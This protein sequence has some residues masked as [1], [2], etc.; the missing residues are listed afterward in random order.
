M[1][2]DSTSSE[3]T[4]TSISSHGDPLAWVVQSTP[5]TMHQ[6]E[7]IIVKDELLGDFC[8]HQLPCLYGG[9]TLLTGI[10][11]KDLKGWSSRLSSLWTART[12]DRAIRVRIDVAMAG[13]KLHHPPY[14]I[15][16]EWLCVLLPL[17]DVAVYH[18]WRDGMGFGESSTVAAS[19]LLLGHT[20]RLMGLSEH[21]GCPPDTKCPGAQGGG[22]WLVGM[23]GI[24]VDPSSSAVEDGGKSQR[25]LEGVNARSDRDCWVQ[26]EDTQGYLCVIVDARGQWTM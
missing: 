3:V 26:K 13:S 20:C 23:S 11:E 12:R 17:R 25:T 18:Q 4:Y 15:L 22:L 19:T 7:E 1:S 14:L 5:S 6:D 8:P 21:S 16:G 9:T 24:T 2:S 10:H